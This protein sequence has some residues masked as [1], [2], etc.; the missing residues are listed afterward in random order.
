ML[1]L[2]WTIICALAIY[3][4]IDILLC[5]FLP[6]EVLM[7]LYEGIIERDNERLKIKKAK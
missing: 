4:L 2:F 3:G 1:F 7:V 5:V 6:L